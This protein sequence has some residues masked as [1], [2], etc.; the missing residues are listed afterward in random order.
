MPQFRFHN[1][2]KPVVMLSSHKQGLL[3]PLTYEKNS[4]KVR[5]GFGTRLRTRIRTSRPPHRAE[6]A[7]NRYRYYSYGDLEGT[8]PCAVVPNRTVTTVT[9]T[10]TMD[11]SSAFRVRRHFAKVRLTA[12]DEPWMGAVLRIST[13]DSCIC[14]GLQN[15]RSGVILKNVLFLNCCNWTSVTCESNKNKTDIQ[16]SH[17]PSFFVSSSLAFTRKHARVPAQKHKA[18]A[19]ARAHKTYINTHAHPGAGSRGQTKQKVQRRYAVP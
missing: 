9:T 15:S 11:D 19:Y 10:D 16:S 8:G 14:F 1:A 13:T 7:H 2:R 18:H 6:C 4:A 5:Q 3:K 17:F 12:I